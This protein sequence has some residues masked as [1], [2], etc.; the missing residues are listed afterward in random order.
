MSTDQWLSRSPVIQKNQSTIARAS[1]FP[2]ALKVGANPGHWCH[3]HVVTDRAWLDLVHSERSEV[4]CVLD[5]GLPKV[6][7]DLDRPLLRTCGPLIK[8]LHVFGVHNSRRKCG[9]RHRNL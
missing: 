8:V 7:V 3:V 6:E 5:Q 2:E 1:K 9:S 4:C